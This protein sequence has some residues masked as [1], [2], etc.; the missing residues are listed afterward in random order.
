MKS[1]KEGVPEKKY[2]TTSQPRHTRPTTQAPTPPPLT[3]I[4]NHP[5]AKGRPTQTQG[6]GQGVRP[7]RKPQRGAAARPRRSPVPGATPAGRGAATAP[8]RAPKRIAM[9]MRSGGR[10]KPNGRGGK[11]RGRGGGAERKG[12]C[13]A[14]DETNS[15]TQG[16][17]KGRPGDGGTEGRTPN[18][19]GTAGRGVYAGQP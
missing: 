18:K 5:L 4:P 9:R 2:R 7:G 10:S 19:E 3:R 11:E 8:V 16:A 6:T 13:E 14:E 1:T 15:T 17:G 12:P